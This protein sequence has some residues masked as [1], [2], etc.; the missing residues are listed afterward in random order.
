MSASPAVVHQPASVLVTGGAGFIGSNFLL[1]MVRNH[2]QIRFINLDA[3]TYAGNLHNLAEIESAPNYA[4]VRGDITD[5]ALLERLFR[6]HEITTVVHFAAESHVDRSITEPISFV[7][8]NVDG[9]AVLLECARQHWANGDGRF[10]HVSTDEVFGSLGIDGYFTEDTPYAPRSPYSAS[11]AASDHLVRAYGHTYGL[12]VVITN[13][14]NNYGPFQFPEKLIPLVIANARDGRA[15]PV[16]GEG[17]NVRDWLFVD[18][19]CRAIETVLRSGRSGE[20]YVIGGAAERRNIDLVRQ[21]LDLVDEQIGREVGTGQSLIEFVRDRPGH[22]FR[23]AIDFSKLRDELGWTPLV[24]LEEGLR[25]TV[26]WY[27]QNEE[28]LKTVM[29]ESYR[30]YYEAQYQNR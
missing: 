9:T 24:T 19:H 30:L 12:P 6:E 8:T 22:D 15:V 1:R 5:H 20:T 17:S 18:D 16:Y 21:V 28:W 4:F 23:Y 3:L 11:K 14:S 26:A 25:R 7:R 29:N 27:L 2:P 13:C 10:L